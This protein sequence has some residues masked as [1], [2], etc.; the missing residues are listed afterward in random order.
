MD[1]SFLRSQYLGGWKILQQ[2]SC[3]Y[4]QGKHLCDGYGETGCPKPTEGLITSNAN[5]NIKH[6]YVLPREQ[7]VWY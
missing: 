3:V 2:E 5:E 7:R 6:T 1:Q 4:Y